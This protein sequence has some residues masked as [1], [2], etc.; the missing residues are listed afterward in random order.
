MNTDDD[1]E[2]RNSLILLKWQRQFK[3]LLRRSVPEQEWLLR[4]TEDASW[5]EIV[6]ED[7]LDAEEI[8]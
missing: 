2:S 5:A 3:E 6:V 8:G 4:K 7:V 1:Y